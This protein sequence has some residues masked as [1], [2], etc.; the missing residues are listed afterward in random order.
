MKIEYGDG[1]VEYLGY[2]VG[3]GADTCQA[4]FGTLN[5]ALIKPLPTD[6]PIKVDHV[7]SKSGV[8]DVKVTGEIALYLFLV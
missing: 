8:F 2:N 3:T 4:Q 7:Y 1:S 5:Q 6:P